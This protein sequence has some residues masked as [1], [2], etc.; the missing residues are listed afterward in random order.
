[1]SDNN[2]L[3]DAIDL[4][5]HWRSKAN[6]LEAEMARL[7]ADL[8]AAETSLRRAGYTREPGVKAWKPPL[9]P[10]ASPLLDKIDS[11]EERLEAMTSER[12]KLKRHILAA[13]KLD[14]DWSVLDRLD[15]LERERDICGEVAV[16]ALDRAQTAEAELAGLK[17]IVE[18]GA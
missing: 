4:I 11:L 6:D 1:M 3:I 16:A 18:G 12:D 5:L 7:R 15:D 14:F 17:A 2:Q 10:S 13:G 8:A 9:G